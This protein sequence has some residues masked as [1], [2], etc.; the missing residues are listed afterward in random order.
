MLTLLCYCFQNSL[1]NLTKVLAIM[2]D[3]AND[4]KEFSKGLNRTPIHSQLTWYAVKHSA[5]FVIMDSIP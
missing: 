3:A 4:T 5:S 1:Q 2:Q